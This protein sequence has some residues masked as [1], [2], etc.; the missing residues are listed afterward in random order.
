MDIKLIKAFIVEKNYSPK[1]IYNFFKYQLFGYR[2]VIKKLPLFKI[3]LN[4]NN[5]FYDNF[6]NV[7]NYSEYL[8][9]RI[10]KKEVKKGFNILDVGANIGY[11]TLLFSK[12]V[13]KNGKVSSFEPQIG[14]YE[15]FKKN[16]K[17]NQ[18]KNVNSYN[19]GISNKNKKVVLYKDPKNLGNSSVYKLQKE[20]VK[21]KVEFKNPLNLI[22]HKIDLIKIDVEG[23]ELNVLK[24]LLPIID[25]YKPVIIFE[26]SS[27]HLNKIGKNEDKKILNFLRKINYDYYDINNETSVLSKN[28][29]TN[30]ICKFKKIK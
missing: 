25:K 8:T 19:F 24:T 23:Y 9:E 14:I 2:T 5:G 1:I 27:K 20:F 13:G 18:I 22:N 30:L 15:Q 29:H 17:I 26:F 28:V 6:I 4:S 12:L 7:F 3:Y 21:E 16:L 11:F 10:I